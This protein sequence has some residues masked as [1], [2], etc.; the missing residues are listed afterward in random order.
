MATPSEPSQQA[1][2]NTESKMPPLYQSVVPLSAA[3]HGTHRLS[4]TTD[5]LFASQVNALPLAAVEFVS[6]SRNFPIVFSSKPPYAPMCFLGLKTGE[7][8]FLRKDGQWARS[9]YIP[10]YVRRYPF[11]LLN[12]GSGGEP[13]LGIETSCKRLQTKDGEALFENGQ[14]SS[15]L[16]QMLEFCADYNRHW[17]ISL[18]FVEALASAQILTQ[19]NI[20]LSSME[21]HRLNLTDMLGIDEQRLN[22]LPAETLISWRDKGWLAPIYAQ[23]A[24]RHNW[25]L[26]AEKAAEDTAQHTS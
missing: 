9:V 24:S 25:S 8:S 3:S 1:S 18:A 26:L 17:S 10:A 23:I 19:E 4:G 16:K 21:N 11:L 15:F 2:G 22:E 7:N 5:F 14:P 12:D 20:A 6:A 13:A